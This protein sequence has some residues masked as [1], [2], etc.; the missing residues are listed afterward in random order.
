MAGSDPEAPQDEE[1]QP[2]E[3][4]E[5]DPRRFRR[6]R[7]GRFLK[8]AALASK[9][10]GS[11]LGQKIKRAFVSQQTAE[12]S[13]ERAHLRNAGRVAQAFG[14][15][16]GAIMKVGQMMSLY[17]DI[18]PAEYTQL[19]GRLQKQAP[20]VKFKVIAAQ[21][22]AELGRPPG[23]VF[24]RLDEQP[25][26]SAS[27]GQVHRGQL[28][29]GR[30][31]AVK[32][33]YPG[34]D[35]TVDSDVK[36]LRM[37][38]RSVGL[39]R[40]DRGLDEMI[41][42]VRARLEEELD[43]RLELQNLKRFHQLLGDDE[44]VRLPLGLEDMST[45]RVLFMEYVPGRDFASL[46]SKAD[47][48][49]RDRV[50]QTLFD[51]FLRQFFRLRALHADPNPA[52]F[53]FPDDGRIVFYDFGCVRYYPAAFVDGYLAIIRDGLARKT[54]RLVEDLARIGVEPIDGKAMRAELVARFAEPALAPFWQDDFDFGRSR[55]HDDMFK[56]GR[57]HWQEGLRLRAPPELV[58]LDRVIVGMYNNLR[59]L[60]ARGNWRRILEPYLE[61]A[62]TSGHQ[63]EDQG[64]TVPGEGLDV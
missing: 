39:M 8:V 49:T 45:Q 9:V 25:F 30:E 35:R 59:Q 60:R 38:L 23:E 7:G 17:A 19:L 22:E 47:Q 15:L 37:V 4:A 16:K 44:R 51:L 62:D 57:E 21:L 53:A 10:S 55:I 32:I 1:L 56:L 29:D 43:Y 31:V 34:V 11:Y 40:K 54:E 63:L 26:A 20:P 46:C 36:N 14:E 6:G 61:I 42:E 28:H 5:K 18:L 52:N 41:E 50:G 48:T 33:Q 24:A 3:T 27:I 64:G 2:E 13:L 12:A 58:F